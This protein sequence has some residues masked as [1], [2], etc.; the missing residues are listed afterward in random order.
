SN[1]RPAKL[2]GSF[3]QNWAAKWYSSLG[4]SMFNRIRE[5][6]RILTY[7]SDGSQ[8]ETPDLVFEEERLSEIPKTSRVIGTAIEIWI[9]A[10]IATQAGSYI[11]HLIS[12]QPG[13]ASVGTISATLAMICYTI[14]HMIQNSIQNKIADGS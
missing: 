5:S 4:T 12:P 8:S 1:C 6:Y 11:S 14:L 10:F 2:N 3:W 13:L 7:R 9:V